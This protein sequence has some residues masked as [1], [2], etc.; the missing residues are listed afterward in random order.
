M[1]ISIS[2]GVQDDEHLVAHLLLDQLGEV[3]DVGG[4]PCLVHYS[5]C[6]ICQGAHIGIL[7]QT[8][9]DLLPQLV[10]SRFLKSLGVVDGTHHSDLDLVQHEH[11]TI[12]DDLDSS[13]DNDVC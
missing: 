11:G 4:L 9:D 6:D 7:C 12:I 3:H 5:L 2:D 13:L 10:K 8:V 1:I